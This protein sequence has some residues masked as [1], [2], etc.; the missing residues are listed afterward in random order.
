MP[1]TTRSATRQRRWLRPTD[2]GFC[3]WQPVGMT[4]EDSNAMSEM[5]STLHGY[6]RF[7]REALMWK[8]EGLSDYDVRRPLVPTG[9]NLLGLVKHV[10]S[11]GVGYFGEVFGRP[12]PEPL[13]WLDEDAEPN[14]DMYATADESR[15]DIV[16]LW[17]RSWAHADATI[18]ALPLDA[19]GRVPWWGDKGDVTLHVLLVHMATETH[20]HAGHA[21]IVRELI[22][23]NAGLRAKNDNLP[24]SDPAWWSRYHATVQGVADQFRT[25]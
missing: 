22:D 9:T 10:S 23:G 1:S 4:S 15:E 2:I 3:E 17:E 8:L 21:D 24:Q 16:G 20:R 14:S 19:P 13:P 18:D 25:Q 6:L 7:G 12:F 5:K 11:V